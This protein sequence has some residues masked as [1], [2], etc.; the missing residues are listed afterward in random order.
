[1]ISRITPLERQDPALTFRYLTNK[2]CFLF[3]QNVYIKVIDSPTTRP[4]AFCFTT[5]DF[6]HFDGT[7]PIQPILV[8]LEWRYAK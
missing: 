4:N 3:R 5:C 2:H 1:M 6:A 8:N 7:E